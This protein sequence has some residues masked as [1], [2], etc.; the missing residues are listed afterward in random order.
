M[1]TPKILL[2]DDDQALGESFK[3]VLEGKGYDVTYVEDGDYA[4]DL[5]E[6]ENFDAVITDFQMPT[7]GGME[8]LEQARKFKPRL[9]IIIMTAFSSADRA[10]EATKQGAFD[11]LIKP[12]EIP[13]LL[14]VVAKAVES[15]RLTA[16]AVTIGESKPGKDAIIGFSRPMQTVFKEVGRVAATPIPILITGETGTGKELIARAIFQHSKRAQKPFVAVNCAAIP[17]NLIE[18]E[19]FGHERGAFTGAVSKR[20]GRF[21]QANGG[22]LFLDEIGDLPWQT[23]VKLLRVL[24]EKTLSRVGSAEAIPIDVRIISATHRDLNAMIS[25]GTFREDLFF[26][27]NAAEI[28]LPPLTDYLLTKFVTEFELPTASIHSK[29][30]KLLE[31]HPWSG[32]VRELENVVRKALVDTQGRTISEGIIQDAIETSSRGTNFTPAS[33]ASSDG[34]L[35]QALSLIVRHALH[36]TEADKTESLGAFAFLVE[37]IEEEL[38]HQAVVHAQSNQ[39]RMAKLL[40]ISRL[41]VRE[42]L[43][44]YGLLPK[45]EK[46]ES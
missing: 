26:R 42:K 20:I 3:V 22:T 19:L 44:K 41:T 17:E 24:Q 30:R 43:D 14:T 2:A 16:K 39:S 29:A 25:E 45:R 46:N 10:I 7:M 15:G 38:F 8:L 13:E 4:L 18:S 11:Y 21:E 32:N 9:P 6:E 27:L 36:A 34:D 28:N 37:E 23:Q 1:H 31:T 33:G 12:V 35:Q 40:G 5:I